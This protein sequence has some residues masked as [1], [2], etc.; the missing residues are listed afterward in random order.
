MLSS[1]VVSWA[2]ELQGRIKDNETQLA[3]N[4][5]IIASF[6]SAKTEITPDR[7][8]ELAQLPHAQ[9]EAFE[10][11]L[12][13]IDKQLQAANG[14]LAQIAQER[15]KHA[16]A[17]PEIPEATTLERLVEQLTQVNTS[18]SELALQMGDVESQIKAN[19]IRLNDCKH[20]QTKLQAAEKE[21]L[22]WDG[23]N[24]IFGDAEGKK[25]RVIAQSYVLRELLAHGNTF[26]SN[27]SDRYQLMCQNNLT[28]L[29]R[30]LHFGGVTRPVDLVSGGESFIVSLALA[31]GLS[32]L[33]RNRL[34]ADILFIDE[35][36]GTLDPSVL[37]VVMNTLGQL[38]TLG[39]RRVGIISHVE[40]LRER[41]PVK[42]HVAKTNNTT[43]RIIIERS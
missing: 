5:C 15:E 36:F 39:D 7:L 21:W 18:L 8:S 11:E 23:L 1:W 13:T 28:I 43:S 22:K 27:F 29:V 25:F 41:I 38:Q 24:K 4:K 3:E 37:E 16:Q 40:A 31:L 10:A 12:S 26:L 35:G 30:D 32:S 14:A 33:N 6:L 34:S 9:V 20:Q 2:S 19:D 42:I 17:K